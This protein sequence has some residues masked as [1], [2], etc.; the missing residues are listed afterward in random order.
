MVS[1]GLLLA[2]TTVGGFEAIGPLIRA[3][4]DPSPGLLVNRTVG[5]RPFDP[6]DPIRPTVVFIHGLNPF[7]GQLRFTMAERLSTAIAR[8]YG[9]AAFNVLEWD[10]NAAT[11]VSVRYPRNVEAAVAQ[12]GRL[13]EAMRR[14]RL[15]PTRVYLIGHSNGAIVAASA[16]RLIATTQGRLIAQVTFLESA[17]FNHHVVFE[18]FVAGTCAGRVENIWAAGPSGF[19]REVRIAGVTNHRVDGRTPYLGVVL[20]TRSGHFDV[21]RWYIDGV[22]DAASRVGFNASLLHGR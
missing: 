20:P 7:P 4:G 10:W 18:R 17:S 8:K 6:P 1:L 22:N 9:P 21:V 3:A 14:A 16:A 5:N 2:V 15:D 12:G 11:V 19:G 13:A